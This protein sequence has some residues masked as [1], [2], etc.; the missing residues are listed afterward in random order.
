MPAATET[1]ITAVTIAIPRLPAIWGRLPRPS[2]S[3]RF[4]VSTQEENS[5][6]FFADLRATLT[7]TAFGATSVLQSAAIAVTEEAYLERAH[8]CMAS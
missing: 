1:T 6:Y 2:C 7:S 3:Y 5:S 8:P 4:P